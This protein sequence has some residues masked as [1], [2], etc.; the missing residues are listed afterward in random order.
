MPSSRSG[1]PRHDFEGFL[2]SYSKLRRAIRVAQL[3]NL[4]I[5]SGFLIIWM[6]GTRILDHQLKSMD[7]DSMHDGKR[8]LAQRD[9]GDAQSPSQAPRKSSIECPN[10]PSH[11][12]A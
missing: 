9:I 4:V 3:G 6:E 10:T 2:C 11:S 1:F 7:D 12:D 5:S 8:H